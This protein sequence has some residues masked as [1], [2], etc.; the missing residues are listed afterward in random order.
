MNC[1]CINRVQ[2]MLREKLGDPNAEMNGMYIFNEETHQM[3]FRPSIT[4]L[5]YKKKK[6]G[7]FNKKRDEMQLSYGYCPFCGKSITASTSQ[8]EK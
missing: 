2:E 6:D 7:T 4:I 1:N 8:S 3:E 5:Y